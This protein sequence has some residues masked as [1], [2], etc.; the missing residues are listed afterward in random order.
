MGLIALAAGFI[1]IA[2]RKGGKWHRRSG[3]VFVYTMIATGITA[4]GISAYE[5]KTTFT[6]GLLAAYFVFTAYTTV[7][8]L[9]RGGRRVDIGLMVLAFAIAAYGY[10][11]VFTALGTPRKSIEGVPAGMLFFMATVNLFAAIGDFRMIRAGGIQGTRRVARHLWR[12]SFALF[13]ASGSFLI[14]QMKF[15]PERIR[16]V[17]LILALAVSPLVLLLYWM[18]RVRLRQNLRG[19]MTAKPIDAR[20]T[21]TGAVPMLRNRQQPDG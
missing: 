9:S 20:S 10:L 6:G 21:A 17:P 13:I 14:G 5:G 8:P 1:A 19:L 18:W 12:M 15:I 16:I 3:M 4:T 7:K 2:V 11:G